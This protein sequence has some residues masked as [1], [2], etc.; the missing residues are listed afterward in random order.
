M[1]YS[2]ISYVSYLIH[3]LNDP[4]TEVRGAAVTSLG[5]IPSFN[6][7]TPVAELLK[8]EQV[9][10]VRVRAVQSLGKISNFSSFVKRF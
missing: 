7:A 4:I 6:S 3:A 1:N 2:K 8:K 5:K 10:D 9:V